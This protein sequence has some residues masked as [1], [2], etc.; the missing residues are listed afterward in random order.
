MN[1]IYTGSYKNCKSGNLISISRDK[2]EDASFKGK[3]I[4][5]LAPLGPYFKIWR[6]NRG[7]VDEL[8]NNK[9]YIEEYYKEV[10]SNIDIE[11]ILSK[12][13]NPILLCYEE[14]NEFCHRHIVAEYIN[15]KYNINVDEIEI[16]EK[17]NIKYKERPKYIREYLEEIMNRKVK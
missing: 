6:K 16:D 4:T 10:L 11:S 7:V 13:I 15:I 17:G 9:Y 2:G 8:E 14:S 3:Y 12:E 1:K 5:S